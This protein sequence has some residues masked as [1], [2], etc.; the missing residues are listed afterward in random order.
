MR[1]AAGNGRHGHA[2]RYGHGPG[3]AIP[4]AGFTLTEVLVAV[5]IL[6]ILGGLAAPSFTAF[7]QREATDQILSDLTSTVMVARGAA[8]KAGVPV[9]LCASADGTRCAPG[10]NAG[11]MAFVDDNRNR[12]ADLAETIV[13]RHDNASGIARIAVRNVAGVKVDAVS[14]NY[15]G[16][17]DAAL[18]IEV[19]N[20][21]HGAAA[22]VSPFGKAR[23]HD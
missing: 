11:W 22:S 10:W 8:V 17:P 23:R 13:A 14:F 18:I 15:R 4:A 16:A 1:H 3:E 19:S 7:V 6:A 21:D 2:E 20:G 12:A 5:A 9:V